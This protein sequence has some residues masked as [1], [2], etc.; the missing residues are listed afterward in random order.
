MADLRF[1]RDRL[2]SKLH[3]GDIG[4]AFQ[5][6]AYEL[7]V[8]DY[9]GLHIFPVGVKDGGIDLSEKREDSSVFIECKYISKDGLSPAQS[10]WREVAKHLERHICDPTHPTVGQRQYSPWFRTESP[11]TEYL[12]CISSTLANRDQLDRLQEEIQAFFTTLSS[13]HNHLAHLA[14]LSVK[15]IDWS[16]LRSYLMRYP[17]I[18]LRW[19]PRTRPVGLVPIDDISETGSFRSYLYS[20][21]LPYYSRH[22]HLQLV[23][24]P[25][26]SS[27]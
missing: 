6:F 15:V 24:A 7:L 26:E 13:R 20:D 25:P 16:D 10:R 22:S 27:I 1:E 17:R 23:P 5:R 8:H 19:F 3:G 9:P 11:V 2:N 18:L 21:V 14:S 12:F 4:E